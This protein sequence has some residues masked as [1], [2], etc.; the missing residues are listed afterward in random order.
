MVPQEG[1]PRG[2]AHLHPIGHEQDQGSCDVDGEEGIRGSFE[3]LPLA[4][5]EQVP[6]RWMRHKNKG[7]SQPRLPFLCTPRGSG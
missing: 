7:E 2:Q 4:A 6:M 1:T 3:V 5:T